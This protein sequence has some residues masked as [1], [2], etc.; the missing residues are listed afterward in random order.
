MAQIADDAFGY[1]WRNYYEPFFSKSR[2]V[3]SIG[4]ML[5]APS[6]I[7]VSGVEA[8]GESVYTAIDIHRARR[9]EAA[10]K[11]AMAAVNTWGR[12]DD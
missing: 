1:L 8:G 6:F 2:H 4:R 9:S 3:Q 12:V 10:F 5:H 7:I 11:S